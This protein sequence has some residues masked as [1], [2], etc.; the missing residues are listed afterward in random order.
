MKRE[1]NFTALHCKLHYAS[2]YTSLNSLRIC[3]PM[4]INLLIKA[5][6]TTGSPAPGDGIR[7][8]P[9]NHP[10]SHDSVEQLQA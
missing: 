2:L 9:G 1:K 8:L 6:Q 3:L 7:S 4:F 5:R 10:Q